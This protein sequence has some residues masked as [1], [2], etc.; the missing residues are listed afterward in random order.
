MSSKKKWTKTT[1]FLIPAT[2]LDVH[3]LLEYGLI[4]AYMNDH[5]YEKNKDDSEVD[6]YLLF[7]SQQV[8]NKDYDYFYKT[9]R[10]YE[11]FLDEYE[12]EEGTVFRFKLEEE[13]KHIK[14][15]LSSSQYSKI[16]RKYVNMFF[17]PEIVYA[18]DMYGN[19]LTKKSHNY[20]ILI[21]DP[22][23]RDEWEE[24][25]DVH[26]SEDLELW[27]KLYPQEEIL[28]YEMD[29]KTSLLDSGN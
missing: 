21:K 6:I 11:C 17:P 25:L 28:H 27:D 23:L 24:K 10:E 1:S 15:E 3:I 18:K 20:R 13:W 14:A 8:Y 16:D 19:P 22:S 29:K 2:G 9:L 7:A 5:T 4:N 26:I 12:I